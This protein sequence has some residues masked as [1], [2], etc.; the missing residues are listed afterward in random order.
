MYCPDYVCSYYL[1]PQDVL[2]EFRKDM[3]EAVD[4]NG[5]PLKEV[6]D[7]LIERISATPIP[8][9]D[10]PDFPNDHAVTR[11]EIITTISK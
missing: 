10:K 9:Y 3:S 1:M 6:S 8:L 5:N 4:I 11:D 7:E 2:D